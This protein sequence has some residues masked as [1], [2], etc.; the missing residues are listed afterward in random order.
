MNWS[1][2]KFSGQMLIFNF[3]TF[4]SQNWVKKGV[5]GR[6]GRKAELTEKSFFR[7]N[8]FWRFSGFWKKVVRTRRRE[9]WYYKQLKYLIFDYSM[10]MGTSR[11]SC[12]VFKKVFKNRWIIFAWFFLPRVACIHILLMCSCSPL[13]ERGQSG[14]RQ[15]AGGWTRIRRIFMQTEG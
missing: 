2:W 4:F 13:L 5:R 15:V 8:F 1:W 12:E 6:N 7:S 10:D 3:L 14:R 11:I 9:I